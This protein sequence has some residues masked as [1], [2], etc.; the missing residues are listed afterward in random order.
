ML[1]TKDY[2]KL[3][4]KE[5]RFLAMVGRLSVATIQQI[6]DCL[7]S[8]G[9]YAPTAAE[10]KNLAQ[11]GFMETGTHRDFEYGN[12]KL[13]YRL[14][15]AGYRA[16]VTQAGVGRHELFYPS[17]NTS[18]SGHAIQSNDTIVWAWQIARKNPLIEVSCRSERVLRGYP[19]FRSGEGPIGDA[20]IGFQRPPTGHYAFMMEWDKD[21]I[22]APDWLLPRI[23]AFL[24][25][26]PRQ[27]YFDGFQ[28]HD[29]LVF[30]L[31]RDPRR[32]EE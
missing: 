25:L 28:T 19:V 12:P 17:D 30:W 7:R 21:T 24:L 10:L 26:D 29:L 13:T 11:R 15:T 22:R 3:S 23:E 18:V 16:V 32:R 8:E 20:W 1:S 14:S 6:N 9:C 31:T 2:Q 5:L 4:K 27:E